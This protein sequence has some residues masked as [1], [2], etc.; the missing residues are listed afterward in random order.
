MDTRVVNLQDENNLVAKHKFT[1]DIETDWTM[2]TTCNYACGYCFFDAE[3]LGKK[4]EIFA[5]N[6]EWQQAFD[7]TNLTWLIHLTGGEPFILP[8]FVDLCQR[9][10]QKHWISVNSNLTRPAVK[11]FAETIDPS[12][13]S[14]INAGFHPVEWEKRRGYDVFIRHFHLL[15]E[16]G[17]NIMAS[18][19]GDP[20]ALLQFDEVSKILSAEGI[21]LVPKV[22]R[23]MVDGKDYPRAY[24]DLERDIFKKASAAARQAYQPML[25]SLSEPPTINPFDD[26]TRL[27][28]IMDFRGMMCSSGSRFVMMNEKGDVIQCPNKV[29]GNLL[30]GTFQPVK[31]D[32]ICNSRY[33]YYFCMKYAD[34]TESKEVIKMRKGALAASKALQN[35]VM[36]FKAKPKT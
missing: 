16:H 25:D 36:Q 21:V 13:V 8:E 23:G 14:M 6:A 28:E 5:T 33:C 1:Y 34:M 30:K 9:L 22:M 26:D 20:K 27:D 10:T 11:Q 29:L 18:M 15:K 31:R 12:R 17:F 4:L 19:V 3:E 24:T 32:I 35:V 2:F 7:R